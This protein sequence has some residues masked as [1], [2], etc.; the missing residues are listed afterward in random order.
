MDL[1]VEIWS[2]VRQGMIPREWAIAQGTSRASYHLRRPLLAAEV[3]Y[4]PGDDEGILIKQLQLDM[5]PTR[6]SLCVSLWR[7]HEAVE[8]TPAQLQH[9]ILA[10]SIMPQLECLHIIGRRHEPVIEGSIEDILISLLARH[11][12]VLS[13]Q[14][15]MITMPLDTP[16]L[17]H[18][19]L[20][21]E[22]ELKSE[23]Y[24]KPHDFSGHIYRAYME[25][26]W[27]ETIFTSFS[28]LKR[29]KTLYVQSSLTMISQQVDLTGCKDLHHVALQG[30]CLSGALILPG[31][32]S[33][34]IKSILQDSYEV[35]EN[36][37]LVTGVTFCHNA[38]LKLKT[39]R[40]WMDRK[41]VECYMRDLKELRLKVSKEDLDEVYRKEGV[42]RLVFS[43]HTL[44]RLEVLELA[45]QCNLIASIDPSLR[46]RTLVLIA[47]GTL[48]VDLR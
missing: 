38:S 4:E 1:P 48:Q 36:A 2:I 14:V 10:G 17:Q 27:H 12:M 35:N 37:Y 26:S 22:V 23:K 3:R 15:K 18:L 6:Q 7:L 9:L 21:L 45:V 8:I 42:L 29:L 20:D 13:L 19:V 24:E 16:L 5:W 44:P 39:I 11:A 40:H 30:V 43:R 25:S 32:C 41:L 46:L 31:G 47:T 33:L 28:L 34:H